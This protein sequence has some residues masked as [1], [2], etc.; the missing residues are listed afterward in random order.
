[1]QWCLETDETESLSTEM[2]IQKLKLL[3]SIYYSFK[4]E[5]RIYNIAML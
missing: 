1:M 4:F 5:Y 3:Q 2:L